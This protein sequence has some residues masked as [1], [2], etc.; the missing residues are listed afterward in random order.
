MEFDIDDELVNGI[1]ASEHASTLAEIATH[2][3]LLALEASQHR[4]DQRL[5]AAPDAG[6]LACKAGC[7]WC[8]YFTID[9]RP[10]EVLRIIDVMQATLSIQEQQRIP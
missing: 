1:I 7:F 5:T 3:P 2:G 9:V 4:H 10:A 8:C 6:T